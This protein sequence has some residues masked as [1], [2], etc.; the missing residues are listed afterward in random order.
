MTLFLTGN[1]RMA[2][3]PCAVLCTWHN[4]LILDRKRPDGRK[5]TWKCIVKFGC[6]M[7]LHT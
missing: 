3:M 4:D 5:L 6:H 1:G 7:H 2:I